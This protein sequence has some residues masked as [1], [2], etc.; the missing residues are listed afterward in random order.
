MSELV[1]DASARLAAAGVGAPRF[2]AEVLLA[3][4]LGVT[5][6]GL[7]TAGEPTPTQR[8]EF[9]RLLARREAR[10]PLQHVIGTAAFRYLELAVGPGVFIPRPETE[11]LVDAVLPALAE[12]CMVVDLCAGSGALAASVLDEVPGVRVIAVERS[13]DALP[14]LRRN[15]AGARV[16]EGDVTDPALLEELHGLVDVVLSNPPYVPAGVQ[17]EP[18]VR[19]DPAEAVFAGPD[20]LAV[21][22]H[23]LARAAD[24][25]RVGGM[26]AMEHDDSHAGVIL[27]QFDERWIHVTEHTDLAG[28]PRYVTATRAA[29]PTMRPG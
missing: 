1:R 12:G 10:E 23:V 19:A 6:S 25:L 3:H 15:A 28:R 16:V 29:G 20:G 9:E 5:R 13:P 2:D 26:L 21:I 22:P 27:D 24:L 17:V 4:V 18:E 7:L 14:R 11:L 8:A